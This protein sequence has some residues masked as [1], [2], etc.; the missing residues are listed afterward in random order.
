MKRYNLKIEPE[1]LVDI[2]E[3]TN[4]Y[5]QQRNGLGGQFQ[6]AVIKQIDSLSK[7]PQAFAIRYS[8]IR[9]VAIKKF[10]YMVHF[11]VNETDNSVEILAIISTDRNPK[12]WQEK[13]SK[14]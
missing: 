4:W 14:H 9:C 1:A 8:E 11:F 5:N 12:V 10:P 6:K 2:Q 13:T 3:I 7:N